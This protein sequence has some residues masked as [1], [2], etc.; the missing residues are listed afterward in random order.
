MAKIEDALEEKAGG[1]R[2][3]TC[4]KVR[5]FAASPVDGWDRAALRREQP[6]SESVKE[7]QN[8]LIISAESSK[9]GKVWTYRSAR[10]VTETS[11][12]SW[13]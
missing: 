8:R 2:R 13:T 7:L 4:R 11:L 10:K 12:G 3:V 5:A 1:Q 9:R 6:A